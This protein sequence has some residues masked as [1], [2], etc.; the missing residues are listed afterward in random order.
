[1]QKNEYSLSYWEDQVRVALEQEESEEQVQG[2][3]NLA[4]FFENEEVLEGFRDRL[5]SGQWP[6]TLGEA[7]DMFVAIETH[8]EAQR[9]L[10]ESLGK[11]YDDLRGK[12]KSEEGMLT[13]L[14]CAKSDLYEHAI[15]VQ[16]E[17][18]PLLN[19]N[20]GH[21][22]G[23]R[24]KE[25]ILAA[26][27]RRKGPVEKAIKKFN[28]RR[29]QYLMAFDPARLKLAQMD[30]D[31]PEVA[32]QDIL[33]DFPAKAKLKVLESE[34]RSHLA[35]HE[36]LMMGWMDDADILWMK[37]RIQGTVST[38]P[39]FEAI[40]PIKARLMNSNSVEI[41]DAM[42]RLHFEEQGSRIEGDG[43]G[44]AEDAPEGD[45]EDGGHENLQADDV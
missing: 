24:L 33:P 19:T 38:H 6:A 1:M 25:R 7:S 32:F 15:D 10:A 35:A 21:T 27:K 28:Q 30:P 44:Q 31:N 23:T 42:D 20:S 4:K 9:G 45:E 39:W 11:D 2:K 43:E 22:L 29:T 26:I 36:R 37:T 16:S 17:R 3:K 41:D 5:R 14:W 40:G 18:E 8:E 12:R 13:L 34:L